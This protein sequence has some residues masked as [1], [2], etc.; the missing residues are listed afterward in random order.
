MHVSVCMCVSIDGTREVLLIGLEVIDFDIC[1]P[2]LV[3]L[4]PAASRA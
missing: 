1:S 3:G 4:K 2:A